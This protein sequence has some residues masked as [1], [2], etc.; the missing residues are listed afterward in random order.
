MAYGP[1]GYRDEID[2]IQSTIGKYFPTYKTQVEYD[3]VSV[4]INVYRGEDIEDRF[5]DLRK[6]MVPK[7]YIPYL[8]EDS[9]E[10]VISVKKTPEK[11]YRSIKTNILMLGITIVT[12]LI[13]GTF[14]WHSYR[15]QGDF[16]SLHNILNGGL[17]FTLPLMTILGVH[18]LSHYFLAKGHSIHASLPFFIPAPPP[19]G[20]IGA[21]ISIRE[22]IPDKKSLLDV[23][24]AGP[25]G[26]LLVAIPVSIIGL[27]LGDVMPATAPISP[28]GMIWDF[29]FPAILRVLSYLLPFGEEGS[30]HPTLF[31]GWVGFLVTGLNLLPAG[32]LDGGHVVRALFGEK[33][34]YASYAAVI[35]LIAVGLWQ[36]IGWLVF[37]LF[38]L[39]LVGVKHPPPLNDFTNL[40]N[41]RKFIGVAAVIIL[42][43]SFHP[44]PIEQAEYQFDYSIELEEPAM[45]NIS[46]NDTAVYTF[47]ITNQGMSQ[48]DLY[49]I[50][51]QYRVSYGT[52]NETWSSSLY[53]LQNETWQYVGE[54]YIT[55]TLSRNDNITM[56][57]EVEPVAVNATSTDVELRVDSNVTNLRKT[58]DLAVNIGFDYD[59]DITSDDLIYQNIFL[60]ESDQDDYLFNISLENQG[61]I[62][63]YLISTQYV[64][65]ESWNIT[66]DD[67]TNKTAT[68]LPGE[69]ET[70]GMLL[71]RDENGDEIE[72]YPAE[73]HQN[74]NVV[75][76]FNVQIESLGSGRTRDFEFIGVEP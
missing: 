39:F 31:A 4:Y 2:F 20:T 35:F 75:V 44:I 65:N 60:M 17:F 51:D 41:K 49:D 57:L 3:M 70:V 72:F 68:V 38:I 28:Q 37:A 40:D 29:K 30:F 54:E 24:V 1:D 55:D 45:Q 48:G 67:S 11:N 23:G 50:S 73:Q 5:D 22:P 36:Y 7:N 12:T 71:Q 18:E 13:A 21:F 61:R 58:S 66:Y 33:S 32:Q 26:G 6:E 42:F 63:S 64:S 10:Y 52:S 59:V 43:I 56:K 74:S 16:F 46:I 27:Y 14:W 47:T 15:P 62:D 8:R 19:L 76:R 9:G 25:I 53:L 69:S 34:K